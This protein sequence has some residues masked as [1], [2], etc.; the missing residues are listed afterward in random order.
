MR[1]ALILSHAYVDPALRGK[2]RALASRGVEVTVGVPQLWRQ[3]ILG[4]PIETAWERQSG[5]EVFPVPVKDAGDAERARFAGRPLRA[6]LRDKRPDLIQIEEEPTALATR[7]VAAAAR[8]LNV[9]VVLH[10]TIAES[11]PSLM[12]RLRRRRLLRRAAGVVAASQAVAGAVRRDAPAVAVA[13]VPQLGIQ[14][15]TAPEHVPHE[16]LAIGCVGRLVPEKGVD[17]LLRAL[18]ENRAHAWRLTVVG[19]GP[20]RE[21]LEALANELR[22]AARIRWAGGLPPDRIAALWAELDVL[23]AAARGVGTPADRSGQLVAEAMAH[24]VAVIGSDSG[25]LPEVIGDAGVTVAA[26]DPA[27]L[28]DALRSLSAESA[29][30][31]L[32]QAGRARAM[33]QYSD[34][35]VAE[36]T[37]AFWRDVLGEKR[38]T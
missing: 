4:G 22:L 24:E 12:A 21:R 30:R 23:V 32:M 14:V 33:K 11:P 13:V 17:T 1:R 9:P 10:A 26:G 20:D 34:D 36:R 19:E 38:A 2:L 15:P 25:V 35:A 7:Q 28:A 3:P 8:R 18:A 6:L 27:A 16:G 31:P 29:R 5:V 37:L